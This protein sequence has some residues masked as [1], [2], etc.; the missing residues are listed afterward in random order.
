M[1]R[2]AARFSSSL[3]LVAMIVLTLVATLAP[4]PVAAA[5]AAPDAGH[6][7]VV[8]LAQLVVLLQP[9]LP[10]A[11]DLRFQ[12]PSRPLIIFPVISQAV[13]IGGEFLLLDPL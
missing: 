1:R 8:L 3:V 6:S 5:A 7:E 13:N 2:R 12:G 9:D 10:A 4:L 11:V